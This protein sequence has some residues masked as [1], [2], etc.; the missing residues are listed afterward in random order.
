MKKFNFYLSLALFLSCTSIFAQNW[1]FK[2]GQST[3][4]TLTKNKP[5]QIIA[6]FPKD[7]T[8][9]SALIDGF[10]QVNYKFDDSDFKFN[11]FAELHQNT[12]V[13]KEQHVR[14]FGVGLSF[15]IS[16]MSFGKYMIDLTNDFTFRESRDFVKKK[17]TNQLIYAGSL[18]FQNHPDL[19]SKF[20]R[21]KSVMIPESNE[22]LTKFIN[23]KH[24]HSFGFGYLYGS[25][26]VVIRN[27]SFELDVYPFS[28]FVYHKKIKAGEEEKAYQKLLKE[29]DEAETE[30]TALTNSKEKRDIYAKVKR[31]KEEQRLMAYAKIREE[32]S[33]F[34]NILFVRW[35]IKDRTAFL[36]RTDDDLGTFRKLTVGLNY[37][38]AKNTTFGLAYNW[39]RGPDIY[40]GLEDQDFDT[41]VATF[42]LN[43]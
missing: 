33:K 36:G 35:V 20:L 4:S 23:F 43:L 11:F 26:N 42:K 15:P 10:F 6:T 41:F 38:L 24:D 8:D 31:E 29:I 40:T 25:E 3:S 39:Q 5:A 28:A 18:V 12:L 19:I 1:E 2:I 32:A 13:A 7:T 27:L 34:R 30:S 37:N 9:N 16:E 21:T 14:Q 22:K 17:S